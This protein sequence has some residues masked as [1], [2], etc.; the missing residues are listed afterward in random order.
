MRI[1]NV[2]MYYYT[3]HSP[4]TTNVSGA[5]EQLEGVTGTKGADWHTGEGA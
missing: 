1:C 2:Q 5:N 4:V 3:N